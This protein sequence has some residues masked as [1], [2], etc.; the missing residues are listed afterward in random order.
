[1]NRRIDRF[2]APAIALL[3]LASSAVGLANGFVYDDRYIIELNP[4]VASL[5]HWWALFTQSYWPVVAGGD[6]YRPLTVLFFAIEHAIGRGS[7]LPFHIVNVALYALVSVLVFHVAQWMLPRWAAWLTAACFAVHPVHVEAVANAVG[8]EELTVAVLLLVA[9]IRYVEARRRGSFGRRDAVLI[10]GLYA[11]ACFCKEHGIVLP[12]LLVLADWLLVSDPRPLRERARSLRPFYLALVGVAIGFVAVHAAVLASHGLTGFNAFIPFQ[13]LKLSTRDRILTMFGVV[14]QWI[15]LFYWPLKLRSEY[16][17]PDIAIAQGFSVAQVPGML[18]LGSILAIGAVLWRKRPV[19]TFGIA[20]VVITL[21]PA[22]NF[23]VPAGII[24]AERTLFLPS[25]GAMLIL[26]DLAVLLAA[27]LRV[28]SDRGF[29]MAAAAL[30]LAA[31]LVRSVDRTQVWHDNDRVFTQGVIDAPDSYRAHYMLGIWD[32]QQ[33]RTDKGEYEEWVAL[34]L[35]PY[36]PFLSY[37]LADT[38]RSHQ[39]CEPAVQ[40]YTWT[41]ALS[42]AF[43]LG[44]GDDAV[45]LLLLNRFT[46]A[47]HQAFIAL[48][49]SQATYPQ[50][51][52][53]V[54][55]ADSVLQADSSRSGVVQAGTTG[56]VPEQRQ[57]AAV[58]GG[59]GSVVS[60][61]KLLP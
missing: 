10:V 60:S 36:D 40:L 28:A 2:A 39:Q 8:Q 58:S 42:P 26:G 3:A 14:P 6:G 18:L 16:A 12:A 41:F 32:L 1:M 55:L 5:H 61:S 54:I 46:E 20:W 44:H 51:H 23:I 56:K 45:C 50:L 24:L 57:K 17:P 30:L 7:P 59:E 31:G 33:G 4:A 37:S 29:A 34:K 52:K 47:K 21:L 25:V 13:T 19:I 22:S 49:R 48:T 38:Y 11:V 53:V 35:F 43:P 9:L 27:R 15:R